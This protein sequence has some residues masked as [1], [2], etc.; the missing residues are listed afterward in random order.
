MNAI[1]NANLQIAAVCTETAELAKASLALFDARNATLSYV[2]KPADPRCKW[3]CKVIPA[4]V[5]LT[6]DLTDRTSLHALPFVKK[7]ADLELAEGDF[8]LDSEELSH[9]KARGYKTT[10][11]QIVRRADGTLML[12]GPDNDPNG[13]LATPQMATKQAIKAAATRAQ[14]AQ[15]SQG[16]GDVAACLRWAKARAM[17]VF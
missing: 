2:A 7:N 5:A 10:I 15:L 17:G 11:A 9:R 16:T 3:W 12:A 13:G 6:L 4:A 14:W 1:T 8:V